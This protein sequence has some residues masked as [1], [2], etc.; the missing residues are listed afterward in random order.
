VQKGQLDN[1]TSTPVLF[2]VTQSDYRKDKTSRFEFPL[3]NQVKEVGDFWLYKLPKSIHP[4]N[5][6]ITMSVEYNP[7][8]AVTFIKFDL[9]AERFIITKD[10]SLESVGNILIFV[11][12]EA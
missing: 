2:E 12:L 1:E 6:P 11:T 8:A 7:Q 4:D 3:V 10:S 9:E 5:W